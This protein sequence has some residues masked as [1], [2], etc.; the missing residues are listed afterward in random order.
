MDFCLLLNRYSF[1]SV[2]WSLRKQPTFFQRHQWF[3]RDMTPEKRA[4]KF[5]SAFAPQTSCRGENSNC[6][7]KCWPVPQAMWCKALGI[8]KGMWDLLTLF[9]QKLTE[10]LQV[11][12]LSMMPSLH[13]LVWLS[14]NQIRQSAMIWVTSWKCEKKRF[15]KRFN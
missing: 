4:Q 11:S 1:C 7:A 6:V 12:F 9:T 15:H 14:I 8:L 2:M 5:R 3:P 10:R 13:Q